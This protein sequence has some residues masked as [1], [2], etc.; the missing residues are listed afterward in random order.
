MKNYN[1]IWN[2]N[3]KDISV[4]SAVFSCFENTDK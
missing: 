2:F 4:V 1:W 3:K